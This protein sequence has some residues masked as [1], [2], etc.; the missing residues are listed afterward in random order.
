[1]REEHVVGG[2]GTRQA[3]HSEAFSSDNLLNF[4]TS[5]PAPQK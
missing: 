4:K 1:M 5:K 3:A 2:I